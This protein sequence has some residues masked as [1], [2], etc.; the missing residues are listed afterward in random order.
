MAVPKVNLR[1]V[2][3][4]NGTTYFLD[5]TVKGRRIREAVGSNRKDAELI[6]AKRQTELALGQF[7]VAPKEKE[8][9]TIKR[10]VDDFLLSKRNTIRDGSYKSYTYLLEKFQ[11]YFNVYFPAVYTDIQNIKPNYIKECFD[12][13]LEG[14]DSS[15]R[16]WSRKT[17][18]NL[19]TVLVQMFNYAQKQK[20]I[21]HNPASEIKELSIEKTNIAEF[22]TDQELESIWKT[23]NNYWAD[24]LKFIA[25][26]GLRKGEMINLKWKHVHLEAKHPYITIISSDEWKTKTGNFRTIPLNN[27]ALEIIKRWKGRHAEYVFVSQT[28]QIIHPDKPYRAL[29][30]ALSK[31]S[32]DGDVHKLRHTFASKLL[33]QG[34]SLYTVGKLLGHSDSDTTEIYGHLSQEHLNLAITKLNILKENKESSV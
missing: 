21:D 19:R 24:P 22:F 16:K 28:N 23:V 5:F 13:L 14:K 34:E 30:K 31:L 6:Q 8:I 4:K 7:D 25:Y 15:D 1:K 2:K 9:V 17:I 11:N 10:L 26:T 3:R 20:Y 32:I 29:K 18:N 27:V 12:H 33:M